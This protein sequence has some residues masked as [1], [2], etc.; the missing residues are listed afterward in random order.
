MIFESNLSSP[1]LVFDLEFCHSNYLSPSFQTGMCAA[2]SSYLGLFVNVD[3]LSPPKLS[4][5]S[6]IP[7][8]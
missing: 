4:E 1:P 6:A 5:L 2:T 3:G 8:R 7:S